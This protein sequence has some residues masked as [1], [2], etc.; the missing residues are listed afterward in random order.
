ML[1]LLKSTFTEFWNDECPRLAASLAYYALFALP[2]LLVLVVSVA[3][4]FANRQDVVERVQQ[5]T[6]QAMGQRGAEQVTGILE[7]ASKPGQGI[8]SWLISIVLLVVGATGVLAELQTALNRAWRVKPDPNQGI[9]AMLL[10]RV[11]SLCIV[12][13][14]AALL[15]ASLGVSWLLAEFSNVAEQRAPGWIS[16]GLL[17]LVDQLMSLAILTLVF[18]ATFKFLPDAQLAW[19]DVWVGAFITALLFVIG[20][21][22]L[23]LYL[24]WSDPTS[25]YGAAGSLALVLVWIYYS[26]MIYFLGAEFTQVYARSRGRRVA[27]ETGAVADEKPGP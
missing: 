25:A 22:L 9:K 23:G 7:H 16:P 11:I 14:I 8:A 13:G 26:G 4:M 17:R 20:K 1:N 3:G 27:P 5:Y 2:A 18:A 6:E 24:A 15:V 19:T 12:L 10:K 21:V